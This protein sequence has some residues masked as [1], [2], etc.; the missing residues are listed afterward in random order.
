M[1]F[2]AV[3]T[4][5]R[6]PS[7]GRPLQDTGSAY[8]LNFPTQ[9]GIVK[10]ISASLLQRV[11]LWVLCHIFGSLLV[12]V[13]KLNA[14]AAA[15]L[16]WVVCV[17]VKRYEA[18][19]L[20]GLTWCIS[21]EHKDFLLSD[22]RWKPCSELH[23]VPPFIYVPVVLFQEHTEDP[24]MNSWSLLSSKSISEG[25]LL[26]LFCLL[27]APSSLDCGLTIAFSPSVMWV[28]N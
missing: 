20:P 19:I 7:T 17:E 22:M 12:A 6:T 8:T 3:F 11:S 2:S 1:L 5:N 9:R 26:P 24:T 28:F 15:R 10:I 4:Y 23:L 18:R 27:V 21:I 25:C 13:W 16:T 14:E